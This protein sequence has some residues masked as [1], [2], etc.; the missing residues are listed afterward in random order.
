MGELTRKEEILMFV[1]KGQ[2]EESLQHR[3]SILNAFVLSMTGL[4]VILGGV[5]SG[6]HRIPCELREWIAY[7]VGLVWLINFFFMILQR[8]ESEKAMNIMRKAEREL[9]LCEKGVYLPN[10][11]V[12]PR[13]NYCKGRKIFWGDLFQALALIIFGW[14]I[15]II[16]FKLP[17]NCS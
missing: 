2:R 9:K 12:L 8:H 4:M 17:P 11:P 3:R 16:I 13:K 14:L 15:I 1:H 10:E 6:G 5:V 7:V